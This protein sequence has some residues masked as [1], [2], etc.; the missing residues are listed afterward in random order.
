MKSINTIIKQRRK[1]IGMSKLDLA[2]DS[3]VSRAT[4]LFVE[5]EGRQPMFN[6]GVALLESLGLEVVIREKKKHG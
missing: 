2:K 6:H 5:K 1:A 3:G 4:I